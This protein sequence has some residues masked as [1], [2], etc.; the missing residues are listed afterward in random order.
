MRGSAPYR[1]ACMTAEAAGVAYE[2][3]LVDLSKGDNMKPE[4]LALNPQHNIPVL[5]HDDFVMNESRAI[6]T[7]LALE[8]DK[9]KKLYPT[10]CN[11]AQARVSQRMYFDTGVF[12]KA[13]GDCVYPKM[14]RN[15]DASKE[16]LDKLH[17]V[18]GWANDMVKESGYVA[19]TDHMT[20]ADLCWVATYSTLKACDV[21]P[22]DK[23]KELEAW[24]KKVVALI[25]NYDK[26][27]GNG[28]K[29]FGEYYK[30]K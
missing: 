5:K 1:I 27:N 8:F 17:M 13:L 22:L 11:K 28:V 10:A 25:P 19:G 16:S 4:F 7:Y 26:A 15:E 6:A 9:S 23:Y 21:V 12:Y 18:L 24:F 14:F 20:I 3:K 29:E 30:S 2:T